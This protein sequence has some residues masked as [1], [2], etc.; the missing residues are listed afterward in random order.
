[1]KLVNSL[2]EIEYRIKSGDALILYFSSKSCSVCSILK[3][4]IE[5]ELTKVFSKIEYYEI[6]C[7]ENLDIASHFGVFSAPTV[8]FYLDGKVFLKEGRNISISSFLNAIKRPYE[9]FYG[10]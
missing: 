10:E 9:M 4:K 7:D 6:S 1:M 3:P 8:L 2:K 5:D